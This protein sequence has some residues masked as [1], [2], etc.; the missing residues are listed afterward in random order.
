V[1]VVAGVWI[2]LLLFFP[3]TNRH[4]LRIGD[5]LAGTRVVVSPPVPMLRDLADR[6]TATKEPVEA[7]HEFTAPQLS[8][9]GELELQVLEDALRKSRLPGGDEVLAAVTRSIARRIGWTETVAPAD[10]AA[11]LRDFYTAQRKHLEHR[12]LLGQ[13]RE[14]KRDD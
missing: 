1:R 9:Y 14:H 3:L 11:F 6:R 10:R 2:L 12:L 4:R 7:T 8:I 13:R 5:L